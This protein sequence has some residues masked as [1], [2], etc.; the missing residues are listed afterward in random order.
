MSETT[1]LILQIFGP[2]YLIAGLSLIL[3]KDFYKSIFD[4]LAKN[5][6]SYFFFG[7]LIIAFGLLIILNN[8]SWNTFPEGLVTFIG[9]A[10]LTKGSMMLV[11][12][13]EFKKMA[14]AFNNEAYLTFSSILAIVI[15]LY[16]CWLSYLA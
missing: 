9:F 7:Y 15:G 12:P 8:N 1:K 6:F 11:F 4:D 16:I 10:A 13:N 3:N 2:L 14:M 5:T